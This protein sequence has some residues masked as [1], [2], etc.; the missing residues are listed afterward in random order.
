MIA[1]FRTSICA[2]T[3]LQQAACLAAFVVS[4][5]LALALVWVFT[6]WNARLV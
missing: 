4:L 3:P 6:R 2:L 5:C 1:R